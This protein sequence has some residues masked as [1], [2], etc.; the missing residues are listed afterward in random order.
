MKTLNAEESKSYLSTLQKESEG[1]T[2]LSILICTTKDRRVMFNHLFMEFRRQIEMGGFKG[3]GTERWVEISPIL[4]DDGQRVFN[5]DN[6]PLYA[7]SPVTFNHPDIVEVLFEEDE[8]Q[9][10]VGA[11]SQ[12]LLERSNG[13][14]VVR[15][16]SDDRPKPYYVEEI[17]KAIESN[18][19]CVGFKIAMTTNGEKPEICC[20]SLKYKVW[21]ENVDGYNYVRNVTHFNPVKREIA[22][23]V[24][25]KD[26]RFGEDKDYSDRITPLCKTEVFIDKFMFDYRYSNA[27]NHNEKYGIK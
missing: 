23:Q 17:I 15:F 6:S 18:P 1:V 22:L 26:I 4:N 12:K 27:M 13:K 20:H 9:M 3:K 5:Q 24:G 16:D 21:A 2:K 25:F 10:S 7:E 11:K 14:Y 8:K 19:D